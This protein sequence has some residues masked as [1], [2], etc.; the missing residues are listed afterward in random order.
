MCVVCGLMY[1]VCM[2]CMLVVDCCFMYV[3]CCV[4]VLCVG[5]CLLLQ[6]VFGV[7]CVLSI[8]CCSLF[9]VWLSLFA[10]RC[11]LVVVG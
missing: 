10:V 7:C 11:L 5:C 9:V 6:V 1:C 4:C 2:L 3:A 8:G